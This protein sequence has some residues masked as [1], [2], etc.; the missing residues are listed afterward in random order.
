[1]PFPRAV[2]SWICGVGSWA[3]ET[4]VRSGV[5]NLVMMDADIVKPSNINRQL[6]ALHST[7]GQPKVEVLALRMR[8]IS[9]DAIIT[10]LAK[11]LAPEEC[12]PFLEEH[13]EG[14]VLW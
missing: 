2:V 13:H 5:G 12:R 6:C 14:K 9:P 8:D 1:M 10:P 3:V 4:L 11:H 7:L